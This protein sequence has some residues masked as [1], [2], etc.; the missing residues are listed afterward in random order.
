MAKDKL[1]KEEREEIQKLINQ[2]TEEAKKVVE[3]YVNNPSEM[4]GSLVQ[5]HENSPYLAEKGERL[6]DIHGNKLK[7]DDD[8]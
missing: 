8:N 7:L 2:L 4:S 1:T 5:V 3:D 6:M